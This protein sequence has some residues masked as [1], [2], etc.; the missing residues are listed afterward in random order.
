MISRALAIAFLVAAIGLLLAPAAGAQ[1]TRYMP[2]TGDQ[3]HYYETIALTNGTGNYTGYTENT[4][5]NGSIA[6]TAT[7]PNATESA[8]YQNSWFYEN[9]TG[10]TQSA[11]SRGAFTFSATSRLYVRGTDNQT[12]YTNPY[13]WFYVDNTMPV[14]AHF[15]VLN[16]GMTVVS[17]DAPF[18]PATRPGSYV[19]TVF[20][21]GNGSYQRHDVYGVFAATYNWKSYF[22]PGTGYIVGYVYTERDTDP[23]GNGFAWTD[24]LSVTTTSYPLTP[25]SGPPSP[26]GG[27]SFPSFL[28]VA[29][30]VIVVIVVIVAV[31][32]AFRS[33]RPRTALPRHTG[34]AQVPYSAPA[35]GAPPP[36]HLRPSDEPAVQ[37]VVLRETVK[38]NCQYCGAL[39]DSTAARCPNCGAPRA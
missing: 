21:E 26:S 9:N 17:T 14:G 4:F 15:F 37:Q 25:T 10:H 22:D 5:V 31:V 34:P 8:T 30:V 29:I 39:I 11:S 18:A 6:I 13:V 3:F 24:V 7:L 12:G 28:L 2:R 19:K 16:T 32:L 27:S 20:A 1:G 35:Y 33:R 38:V 36:I 23:A